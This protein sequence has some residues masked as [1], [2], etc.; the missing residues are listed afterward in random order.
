MQTSPTDGEFVSFNF[1][2]NAAMSFKNSTFLR[3]ILTNELSSPSQKA[4][5]L[6]KISANTK[7]N[8]SKR[9]PKA[10]RQMFGGHVSTRSLLATTPAF[11]TSIPIVN[12][13]YVVDMM[14]KMVKAHSRQ[15]QQQQKCLGSY[16]ALYFQIMCYHLTLKRPSYYWLKPKIPTLLTRPTLLFQRTSEKP[17]AKHV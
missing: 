11:W 9:P 4:G 7:K 3:T 1:E 15:Q 5:Q 8:S 17:L 13:L 2:K 16:T 12:S 10:E 6:W 14:P